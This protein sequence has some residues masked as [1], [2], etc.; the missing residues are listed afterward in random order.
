MHAASAPKTNPYALAVHIRHPPPGI[1]PNV[2]RLQVCANVQFS[3][4]PLLLHPR[5]SHGVDCCAGSLRPSGLWRDDLPPMVPAFRGTIPAQF[6]FIGE[7]DG[8]SG[9]RAFPPH[10]RGY[11]PNSWGAGATLGQ[12]LYGALEQVGQGIMSMYSLVSHCY[13]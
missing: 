2:M 11:I 12:S 9:I 4:V 1:M 7:T 3:L 13:N 5:L 8:S 6:D 10:L